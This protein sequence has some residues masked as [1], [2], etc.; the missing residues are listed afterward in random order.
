MFFVA[1]D[2]TLVVFITHETS[3]PHTTRRDICE[4]VH[5][6]I[7]TSLTT[8]NM[9]FPMCVTPRYSAAPKWLDFEA[10]SYG[11][12]TDCAAIEGPH[13]PCANYTTFPEVQIS[14]LAS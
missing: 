12:C 1:E 5:A 11:P 13:C 2:S 14:W 7:N 6:H 9:C 3:Q 10:C 4:Q 8:N